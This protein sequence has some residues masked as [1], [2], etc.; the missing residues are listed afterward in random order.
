MPRIGHQFLLF[1]FETTYLMRVASENCF[2][3]CGNYFSLLYIAFSTVVL[4]LTLLETGQFMFCVCWRLLLNL[5]IIQLKG[6]KLYKHFIEHFRYHHHFLIA[7]NVM[8]IHCDNEILH[9]WALFSWIV[10]L[11]KALFKCSP[12]VYL[13]RFLIEFET[14]YCTFKFVFRQKLNRT[15]IIY[16]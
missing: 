6:A 3:F 5:L 14:D 15:W 16:L 10:D 7:C 12:R 11:K 1:S 4:A 8:P 9:N 13:F 2:Y